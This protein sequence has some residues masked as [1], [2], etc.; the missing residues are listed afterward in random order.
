VTTEGTAEEVG[1]PTGGEDDR[2]RITMAYLSED[3]T[4]LA[5]LLLLMAG[6]FALA[7]RTTQQGKFLIQAVVAAALAAV[8]I[9]VEW[10]W[11]TDNE[12]IEQVVYRLRDAVASSDVE[13][14][15]HHLTPDVMYV[16]GDTAL[17]SEATRALIS[18][19]LSRVRFEIVR[20]S[21][22][23]TNAATQS[24]R[25]SAT[26]SAFFKGAM[27]TS[28]ASTHFGPINST[29]SLG[30]QE[31]EP[32]VWKVNRITPT[33]FP[34]EPVAM[35]GSRRN[36]GPPMMLPD[37]RGMRGRPKFGRGVPYRPSVSP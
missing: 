30:F 5:G 16:K 15:L 37:D 23:Q 31:T 8:V 35:P 22:L 2:E 25:G 7:L 18:D 33:Q 24:R 11:V 19:D 14:V 3:P 32:G 27:D 28:V 29:W 6:A 9:V 36:M 1:L 26:F 21:N 17:D 13:E 12:R 4:L 34:G 10:L 20:I